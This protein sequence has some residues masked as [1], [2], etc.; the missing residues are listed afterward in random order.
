M[1]Q[2]D[3]NNGAAQAS[4]E[5]ANNQ[6]G[7]NMNIHSDDQNQYFED[8]YRNNRDFSNEAGQSINDR[9]NDGGNVNE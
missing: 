3:A 6:G 5:N 4:S 8:G 1:P 2:N 7:S 9:F